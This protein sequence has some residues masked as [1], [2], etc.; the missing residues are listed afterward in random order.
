MK[1]KS[2]ADYF[3]V[4][5]STI[6][7]YTDINLLLP[8]RDESQA[9][10]TAQCVKDMDD[11][12]RLKKMGFSLK[13]IQ[14]LK[15]YERFNVNYSKEES[16]FLKQIFDDKTSALKNEIQE[17][18]NQI[19]AIQA[20]KNAMVHE[21]EEISLGVPLKAVDKLSCPVCDGSFSIKDASLMN[22]M[23]FSGIL[24][25]KCGKALHI[26]DGLIHDREDLKMTASSQANKKG[27]VKSTPEV[28]N[29]HIA[30][31]KATGDLIGSLIEPWD[32]TKGILIPN[33]DS[34]LLIMNTDALFYEDGLYFLCSHELTS[35]LTLKRKLERLSMKGAFVFMCLSGNYPVVK[36]IS[37]LIDNGGNICDMIKRKSPDFSLQ[38]LQPFINDHSTWL[39]IHVG[40]PTSKPL[41]Q[42]SDEKL[43]YLS[44]NRYMGKFKEMGLN[45]LEVHEIGTYETIMGTGNLYAGIEALTLRCLVLTS[46]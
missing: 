7:Y 24:T 34:D 19:D 14:S 18:T 27:E 40:L 6:R 21:Y 32:H 17:L 23:V 31:I 11:I 13:E 42:L 3:K 1:I 43:A 2:F 16:L 10:Y 28:K 8:V 5:K 33:A 12:I 36:S 35:L 25:C 39:S 37:Y 20:Y 38:R 30:Q 4:K 45:V 26:D 9:V 22:T 15:A 46:A 44:K 29:E 41:L